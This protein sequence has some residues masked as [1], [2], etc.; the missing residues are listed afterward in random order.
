MTKKEMYT[1]TINILAETNAPEKDELITMLEHEIELLN[2]KKSTSKGMTKTQKENL[3]IMELILAD[4]DT[5]AEPV[6]VTELL[7]QGE[8]MTGFTNQKIS[9]LLRKL[10]DAGKVTKVVE[11]KKARFAL[12]LA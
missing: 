4:L 12:A 7:A 1:M 8:N 5:I 9:A 2:R 11:G 3:E 10:V 6:T